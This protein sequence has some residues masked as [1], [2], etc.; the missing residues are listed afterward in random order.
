MNLINENALAEMI[1]KAITEQRP[2]LEDDLT[3]RTIGIN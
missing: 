2:R 1:A 3:G